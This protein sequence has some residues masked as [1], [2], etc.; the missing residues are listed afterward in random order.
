MSQSRKPVK[1]YAHN[2]N[3]HSMELFSFILPPFPYLN[4]NTYWSFNSVI[5]EYQGQQTVSFI[6]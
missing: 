3:L 6:Q 2:I 4:K 5:P 1:S